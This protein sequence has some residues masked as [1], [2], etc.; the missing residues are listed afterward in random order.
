M[1][2][3]KYIKLSSPSCIGFGIE[4]IADGESEVEDE[5]QGMRMKEKTK[6]TRYETF[7]SPFVL[8]YLGTSNGK[9]PLLC[10]KSV[11]LT[12]GMGCCSKRWR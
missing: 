2:M 12:P 11:I 3:I 8:N 10:F 1:E 4:E 7:I 5:N 6:M 9:I